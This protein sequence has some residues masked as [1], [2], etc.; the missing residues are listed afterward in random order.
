MDDL[1]A[2]IRIY[3]AFHNDRLRRAPVRRGSSRALWDYSG[4][5]VYCKVCGRPITS[6]E[7]LFDV[8]KLRADR[9]CA[10]HYVPF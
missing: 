6:G 10:D 1:F 4:Q 7:G 2:E 9:A 5:Q 8:E 3:L